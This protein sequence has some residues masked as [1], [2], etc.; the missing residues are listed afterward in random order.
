MNTRLVYRMTVM[1]I[2]LTAI[3]NAQNIKFLKKYDQQHLYNIALPIGGIGTG[4]VSLG[5]RG[6][7]RD[8][9]IMNKPGKGFSTITTGNQ[10]PFFAIYVKET[11]KPAKSRALLGPLHASEYQHYEGRPVNHHGLPRF[12]TASFE[13]SY[14]FGRV[15]LSDSTMPVKVQLTGF[16]P[17]VPS[18]TE[19][20]STPIAILRYEV[21]NSSS[22][23]VEVAICGTMR[24]FIGIDGSRQ[25]K[26][27]KGDIVYEGANKNKN[28]FIEEPGYKGIYMTSKGVDSSDAAWGTILLGTTNKYYTSYRRSSIRNDW[29]NALLN[30]WDDFSADGML[31]DRNEL[32]DDNPM[33]S[34]ASA[35]AI[36]PG[37]TKVFEFF[38]SWH[39]PNR[40]DWNNSWTF[41]NKGKI[42]GNYYTRVYK[43]AKD[44]ADKVLPKLPEWEQSSIQFVNAFM[45]A[46]LPAE[47]KEAA[48]FNLS[49]L[50]SQT[51]FRLPSG[52]LMGWEG[53]MNET[54]SCYGNC[55]HVWN[56][57]SATSFLFGDL[58]RSMREVEL[59][60]GTKSTGKMMNRVNIPLESNFAIDH[61][62]AADG[63]MGSIMRFYREWKHAGD[64][65]WLKKHWPV[66]KSA[67]RYAWL[68]DSWDQDADGIQE[69]KQHNT[70]D[71][72]YYGP[73]PQMQFWY[74]GALKA[75]A[76]IASYL[77][78]K[79]F[80][81]SCMKILSK[82][83]AWV[84]KNLFNGEYYEHWITDPTTKKFLN[85][86]D[87]TV[88][89][90]PFQLGKGCLVDQL[91][92]Q[93]MAHLC[94]LGYLAEPQ[95]I[96]TALQSIVKYNSVLRF[97][98]VFNN[99]RSYVMDKEPGLIMAS[100][101]KG[102][103]EVPFPY[104]AESMSGFE[105]TAAI[106]LIYE[107]ELENGLSAVRNIRSR[108]DGEKR[109]PYNEPECG[110]HYARAMAS[111]S[112]IPS[113]TGFDYN[114]YKKMFRINNRQ[115]TFFWS[116]GYAWGTYSLENEQLK[117]ACLFGSINIQ[118]FVVGEKKIK[119]P[120]QVLRQDEKIELRVN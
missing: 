44:A 112:L 13:A 1:A 49:T 106:G 118:E 5:G 20:S 98:T 103:L 81:D 27:W 57:E 78:E 3:C 67:I 120:K 16:N 56:Y 41:G 15:H 99:M 97:D 28:T 93:Y 30:F 61:V 108:F 70:M 47:V 26:N 104:F 10:A 9:E 113:L 39:F 73:N 24:N 33:A 109:N 42:V 11:D 119:Y 52:H 36:N 94:G 32:V 84:D 45:A 79:K 82:G 87:T 88:L 71:V 22:K 86:S 72:D 40:L 85:L 35:T 111:W 19:A 50:R 105:Y 60:Y 8:W 14:P 2:F 54:G 46:D 77:G 65:N 80:A 68:L 107:Q 37:E 75:G 66:V 6:E 114:G 110:H 117:V 34:L 92:G 31:T 96:R 63:Q 48:L 25:A 95:H 58:A 116:N 64:I 101:P 74:F 89:V 62:A 51:V 83:S 76:E 59:V 90:P 102:R 29:E 115:G 91:A 69:G 100:W 38:I 21:T 4:T 17:F 23:K 18:N 43:N 12:S 53:I 7:L 55:T